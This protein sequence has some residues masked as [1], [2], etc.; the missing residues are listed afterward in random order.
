MNVSVERISHT[1]MRVSWQ[2]LSLSEARGFVQSYTIA[3][4]PV[5]NTRKR[6]DSTM[7]VD[8]D[9]SASSVDIAGL[10]ED[11]V[12]SVQV[13]AGTGAGMGEQS[14]IIQAE[15]FQTGT[16]FVLP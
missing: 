3:Y 6:Q 16:Y 4:T 11:L 9:G 13:S 7:S 12:Y 5:L 1:E 14:A 2:P 8:A 15:Q 10:E